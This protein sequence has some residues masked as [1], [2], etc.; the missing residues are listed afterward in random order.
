MAQSFSQSET[1][2]T[3]SNTGSPSVD[4][5]IPQALLD[6]TTR[7]PLVDDLI[8]VEYHPHCGRPNE[9]L[10]LHDYRQRREKA[11]I[12]IDETPW[13]PFSTRADFEFAD[14]ALDAGLNTKQSN[15]LIALI[16]RIAKG[17][18]FTLKNHAEVQKRWNEAS[19][20]LT[21][22]RAKD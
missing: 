13:L 8:K 9:Y 22:V 7:Q 12:S 4:S 10:S 5:E 11:E 21:K 6:P 3:N 15:R 19:G 17:E 16:H 18:P 1:P 20:K 2:A 14:I